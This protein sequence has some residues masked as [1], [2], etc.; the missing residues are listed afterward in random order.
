MCGWMQYTRPAPTITASTPNIFPHPTF[1]TVVSALANTLAKD[2]ANATTPGLA[3]IS[4]VL[5]A[6]Q[7]VFRLL[8]YLSVLKLSRELPS[9]AK[10]RLSVA[11]TILGLGLGVRAYRVYHWVVLSGVRSRLAMLMTHIRG[12]VTHL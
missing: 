10:P 5:V 8:G 9:F 7:S 2:S 6:Q 4:S 3:F 11:E 12:L 1:A